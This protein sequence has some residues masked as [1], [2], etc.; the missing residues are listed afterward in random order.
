MKVLQSIFALFVVALLFSCSNNAQKIEQ[1][2]AL[3]KEAGKEFRTAVQEN[4][5][6]TFAAVIMDDVTLTRPDGTV[7]S[8]AEEAKQWFGATHEIADLK[9]EMFPEDGLVEPAKK[10]AWG[11]GKYR[12][13]RT[14]KETGESQEEDGWYRTFWYKQAD[15]S[16]KLHRFDWM[17]HETESREED[18]L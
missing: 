18:K 7:F 17:S 2:G 13:T 1:E 3:V 6:A 12:L 11:Y 15:G 9:I 5:P 8:G 10:K 16:W 4:D 14:N